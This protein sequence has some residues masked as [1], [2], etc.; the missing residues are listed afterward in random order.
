MGMRDALLLLI[1]V[2]EVL[3]NVKFCFV[4]LTYLSYYDLVLLSR[5]SSESVYEF[6]NGGGL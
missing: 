5:A 6:S 4:F 3:G 1:P 2:G